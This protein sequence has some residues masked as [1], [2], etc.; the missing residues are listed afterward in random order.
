MNLND[1]IAEAVSLAEYC[2]DEKTKDILL[3]HL[4]ELLDLQL[5]EFKQ[6]QEE[7]PTKPPVILD[8][9]QRNF[10]NDVKQVSTEPDKDVPAPKCI[11]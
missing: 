2:E 6:T 9:K 11:L 4:K 10:E 3:N 1:C 7:S 8:C 5:R